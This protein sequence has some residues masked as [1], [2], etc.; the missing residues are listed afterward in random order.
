M[1]FNVCTHVKLSGDYGLLLYAD[2]AR[3]TPVS[4]YYAEHK[5][6]GCFAA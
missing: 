6:V 4:G 5:N 1:I 3:F 2:Y